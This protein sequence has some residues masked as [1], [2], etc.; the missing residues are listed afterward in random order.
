MNMKLINQRRNNTIYTDGDNAYKIFNEGYSKDDVFMEAFISSKIEKLGLNIPIIEEI[1]SIEGKWAF[2]FPHIPGQSLYDIMI[3]DSEN[4]EKY[5]N[6]LVDIQ[7][8]IHTRK[9]PQLP[10]QKQ[11]LADYIK[12]SSLDDSLK[13]DLIDMLNSSPKHKKLCHGNFTPHN[14]IIYDGVTYI[15]DWNHATQG[16]AS[17]DIARTYLWMKVNMPDYSEIYL[18]KFCKKTNT[19]SHYVHNWIPIVAAARL[20]KNNPEEADILNSL[21]S[22]T[23]Y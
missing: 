21:I 18:E 9:C 19:T 11:K 17:A 1:T 22:V 12:L 10:I 6:Q 16:N 4:I 14:V 8:D 5:M 2:K 23:E 3:A 20:A 13:I 7:T 15:T